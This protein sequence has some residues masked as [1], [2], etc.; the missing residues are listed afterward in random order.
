[1]SAKSGRKVLLAFDRDRE[2]CPLHELVVGY[3][4]FRDYLSTGRTVGTFRIVRNII[5]V[6][7]QGRQESRGGS[8]KA[9]V[10]EAR[11]NIVG[12]VKLNKWC[13]MHVKV[14]VYANLESIT[15]AFTQ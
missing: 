1:M 14:F 5:G 9:F 6:R 15:Q 11:K 2:D 13:S 4:L 3:P 10:H 8:G 7:C 12:V